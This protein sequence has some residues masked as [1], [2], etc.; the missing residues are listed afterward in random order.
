[1]RWEQEDINILRVY[2]RDGLTISDIAQKMGRS[3]DSIKHAI[4]RYNIDSPLIKKP[5]KVADELQ[6]I[7]NAISEETMEDTIERIKSIYSTKWQ[8]T[9]ERKT[10]NK[11]K[12]FKAY[13]IIADTHVP[14]QNDIAVKAV[15]N[16]M[17]DYAFDGFVVLGDYM[18][19]AP[20]SHWLHDKNKR[21]SLEGM[22]MKED[23]TVGNML[24]DE[25]D[26]RLPKK[27]DK[28]FFW[29]N[30]SFVKDTE[31]LTDKGW[32]KIQNIEFTKQYKIAQFDIETKQISFANPEMLTYHPEP[33]V[34]KIEGHNTC[35]VVDPLHHVIVD[36]KKVLAKDLLNTEIKEKQLPLRC[37]AKNRGVDFTDNE[38]KLITWI[39][40]DA[41]VVDRSKR[42]NT[43]AKRIQFKLSK[44]RKIEDLCF[45]LKE[46]K[47]PYT[48]KPATKSGDNVLQPYLIRIYGK[49]AKKYFKIVTKNKVFPRD[50]K[51]LNLEQFK[52]V[53]DVIAKTDGQKVSSNKITWKTINKHNADIIQESAIK[54]GYLCSI[55]EKQG[56]SG[57]KNGKTQYHVYIKKQLVASYKLKIVKE[58]YNDNIYSITMP[59]GTIVTRYNG[60][61][62]FTGNCDWYHQFIE[63][64]PMLDG[65]FNPTIELKLKERGYKVYEDLNHIER[66]GRLSLTHG[67]YHNKHF[68]TKHIDEFKTN[69]LVG[70]LHTSRLRL[71]NSPA[72]EVAIFG[73]SVG[74]LCDL[75]PAYN[76]NKPN[77]TSHG[78]AVV[79]FY[80]NGYFDVDLKR[81][82]KGK[83]V[84]N[85]KLY[86]GNK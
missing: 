65:L 55:N 41:T 16:M 11:K 37:Y 75:N 60:K 44:K 50:F 86:D 79:Y 48:L 15:L 80:D 71:E 46:M 25:F 42:E 69:V 62:A 39:I 29:G 61:V 56:V 74:C 33:Y 81:I 73:A 82:V 6:E 24:L 63:K 19:M 77:K 34:I 26:K 85:N 78:F 84:F 58:K 35:Q 72:K 40:M 10:S 2:R 12:N 30:H 59:K 43:D 68:L 66:I 70:H 83:F 7:A 31:V 45:L 57:F 9:K 20:I 18:D 38:L 28:R 53:L 4:A 8:P 17:E 64:Y 5:N 14:H 27:C 67:M 49:E 23:Y 1:M 22:R 52:V 32:I 36:D 54:N 76:R 51:N 47:I 21:K 13:L 3:Y